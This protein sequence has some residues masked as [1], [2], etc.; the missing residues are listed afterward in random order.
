MDN[1]FECNYAICNSCFETL[2]IKER[3]V[4]LISV[5]NKER[6]SKTSIYVNQDENINDS[7]GCKDNECDHNQKSLISFGDGLYFKK[8]FLDKK[9]VNMYPFSCS[10]CECKFTDRNIANKKQGK[11][12]LND[13]IDTEVMEPLKSIIV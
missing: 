7:E 4:E 9:K 1:E 2:G 12:N 11:T 3:R 13:D 6:R 8:N 10:I 5:R